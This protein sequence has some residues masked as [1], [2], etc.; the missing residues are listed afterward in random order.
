MQPP[1]GQTLQEYALTAGELGAVAAQTVMVALLPVVLAR[2]APSP[3]WIGIAIGGEGVFALA[4]PFWSG[5]LSDR[6]PERVARR[7][8]RRMAVVG[9]ASLVLAGAVAC[10]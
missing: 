6:L 7:F 3:I 5:A 8:G 1:R 4:V 2:Y 9:G 10:T